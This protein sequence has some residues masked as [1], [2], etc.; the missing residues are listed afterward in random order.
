VAQASRK[1]R[2][3]MEQLKVVIGEELVRSRFAD[4]GDYDKRFFSEAVGYL[5]GKRF[6]RFISFIAEEEGGRL[7]WWDISRLYIICEV[8]EVLGEHV[9]KTILVDLM[10]AIKSTHTG[11]ELAAKRMI[12]VGAN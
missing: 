7:D 11:R 6:P 8:T 3:E 2:D 4:T 5:Y 1:A 10:E 9:N 12:S